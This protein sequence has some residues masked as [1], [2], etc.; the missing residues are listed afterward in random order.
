MKD[1]YFRRQTLFIINQ[2][3]III[4]LIFLA[5]NDIQLPCNSFIQ[6]GIITLWLFDAA[7]ISYKNIR[8]DMTLNKLSLLLI[9]VVWCFLLGLS[10]N[11][12]PIS[13]ICK[14]LLPLILF[15]T[16]N[17]TLSF[18]FQDN[19]Y[20]YK[21]MIYI[22]MTVFCVATIFFKFISENVFNFFL[23][24]QFILTAFIM[25]FIS[26][27]HR[28]RMVFILKNQKLQIFMSIGIVFVPFIIYSLYFIGNAPLLDNIGAYMIYTLCFASIHS[29]IFCTKQKNEN[30]LSLS[31]VPKSIL[32]LL[33]LLS[34]A[35]FSIIF[36][37]PTIAIFVLLNIA[38]LMIQIYTVLLYLQ[39]RKRVKS[40]EY[41]HQGFYSYS[42]SGIRS[43]EALKREISEF[44]HYNVLQDLLSVKMLVSKSSSPKVKEL[45]VDTLEKLSLKVRS[46]TKQYHPVILKSLTLKE[47]YNNLI[48]ATNKTFP[49]SNTE[50]IFNC[51][52]D[53]FLTD[54]YDIIIYRIMKELITNS[55][56]HSA[57]KIITVNLFLK[58]DVITL[59]VLDNGMRFDTENRN[60]MLHKG[61][62]SVYDTVYSLE[63]NIELNAEI[64]Q[65]TKT[66]I[67]IPMKGERSYESFI[68]R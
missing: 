54:P 57:A 22:A 24:M 47:N 58:R 29:I 35:L 41:K 68:S 61:L 27:V 62:S 65:G 10:F 18:L 8:S 17:F 55:L 33:A 45:M 64:G 20:R 51:H 23:L 1:K 5:G 37:I 40:G 3:A 56:K 50:I 21:R 14:I 38:Y 53:I 52:D 31:C 7:Y 36:G 2:L 60:N 15:Q 6:L 19:K 34:V 63:G 11:L 4:Y 49:L 12:Y 25:V 30:Y 66:F 9:I 13:E 42:L 16:L 59:E 28:K 67:T 26:I 39:T 46:Q 32:I 44:L 48:E 43:E